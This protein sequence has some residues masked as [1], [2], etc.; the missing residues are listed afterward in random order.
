MHDQVESKTIAKW[1]ITSIA[2]MDI[3][4]RLQFAMQSRLDSPRP[5]Y[6]G[7]YNLTSN[8]FREDLNFS[9]LKLYR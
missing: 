4:L 2:E 6:L 5:F 3:V 7:F 1:L 8:A 9:V